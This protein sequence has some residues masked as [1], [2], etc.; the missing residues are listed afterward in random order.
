MNLDLCTIMS[1]LAILLDNNKIP[2]DSKFYRFGFYFYNISIYYNLIPS[3]NRKT[4]Y[5]PMLNESVI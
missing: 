5:I 4:K 3:H 1:A 2:G